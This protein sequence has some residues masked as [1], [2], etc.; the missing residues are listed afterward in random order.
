MGQCGTKEDN[1]GDNEA[2]SAS[3]ADTVAT[4]RVLE[5]LA[6]DG[7]AL[8]PPARREGAPPLVLRGDAG[9][10]Q[11]GGKRREQGRW[12]RNLRQAEIWQVPQRPNL[13]LIMA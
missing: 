8:G 3:T 4:W 6:H 11:T 13:H 9:D 7:R 10:V 5:R 12:C 2:E 1:C